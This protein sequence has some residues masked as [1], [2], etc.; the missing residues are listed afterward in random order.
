MTRKLFKRSSTPALQV[1]LDGIENEEQLL[2][3]FPSLRRKVSG[4]S[5]L[6]L[7]A[8]IS[9]ILI[10]WYLAT[11]LLNVPVYI[12]P[13]PHVILLK[14]IESHQLIL[15]HLWVTLLESIVGLLA[16][17]AFGV[18]VACLIVW[19]S[20]LNQAILPILAFLQ[21][22]PKVAI[23]P[24]FI[25]WFGFGIFPKIV[26]AFLISFFPIVI[27]TATGL[28]SAPKELLEL[29]RSLTNRQSE[30]FRR[31]RLPTALP[32]FFSGLKV[33]VTLSVIG[34]LVGEFVGADRGIGYVILV[35]NSDLDAPLMF[36][37][38]TVLA[39]VGYLL[40]VSVELVEKRVIPWHAS[41]KFRNSALEAS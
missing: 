12:L 24:L 13:L 6:P 26:M 25:F 19:S 10:C 2:S 8:A 11:Y 41:V 5:W 3:H 40:F 21:T 22:V 7:V 27:A 34:A 1:E 30:I 15:F 16:A 38:I 33:A 14:V 32:Y 17:I 37:S 36:A 29:I 23:A 31:V 35:A 39:A 4:F 18:S 9:I 28:N 20:R